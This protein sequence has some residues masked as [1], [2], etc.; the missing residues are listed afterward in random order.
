M[1]RNQA[2]PVVKNSK[3]PRQPVD[4]FILARLEQRKISPSS[5]AERRILIRRLTLDLT[6]LEQQLHACQI[7][8][9]KVVTTD[10]QWTSW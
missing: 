2:R 7:S 6:G 1:P 9:G 10:M 8:S 5:E 3:L 4:Y